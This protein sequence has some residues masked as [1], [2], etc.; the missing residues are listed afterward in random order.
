MPDNFVVG[1]GDFIPLMGG[2][3]WDVATQPDLS[4]APWV[5]PVWIMGPYDGTIV[6]YEPMVPLSFVSGQ[7]DK[8]YEES[9]TY[10]G[11][12][13]NELPGMYSVSYDAASGYATVKLEGKSAICTLPKKSKKSKQA[14][15]AGKSQSPSKSGK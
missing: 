4:I 2:H 6:D 9:L 12:T 3:A 14:S 11:Q 10:V 7:E 13:I 8:Y 1:I 5:D 15:K